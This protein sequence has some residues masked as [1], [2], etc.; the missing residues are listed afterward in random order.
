ML[1]WGYRH[2]DRQ[3]QTHNEIH[4]L[5][6]LERVSTLFHVSLDLP[7]E[8]DVIADVEVDGEV[9]QLPHAWVVHGVETLNDDDACWRD[10]LGFVESAVH[11]VVN[12]LLDRVSGLKGLQLLVHQVEVVL[13]SI[14]CC[15]LGDLLIFPRSAAR[16]R[17]LFRSCTL[18][19][20]ATRAVVG[21]VIIEADDGDVVGHECVR[22]PATRGIEPASEGAHSATSE[23]LDKATHEGA[24]TAT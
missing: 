13:C 1:V 18:T 22:L 9:E 5:D 2:S 23:I 6:G 8:L 17:E 15:S 4:H 19:N 3:T 16:I 11:V 21:V 14:Q 24:L 12:G 20:L 10:G 7:R